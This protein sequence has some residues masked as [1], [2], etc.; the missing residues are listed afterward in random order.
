MTK[1]SPIA[2]YLRVNKAIPKHDKTGCHFISPEGM[3]LG[4]LTKFYVDNYKVIKTEIFGEGFKKMYAQTVAYGQ[5]FI[6][7]RNQSSPIGVSLV[8]IKTYMRK[9]FIDLYEGTSHVKDTEKSLDN[10]LN[11]LAIDENSGVGLYD[12]NKPF[13]YTNIVTNEKFEKLRKPKIKFTEN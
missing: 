2:E 13:M 10:K 4:R 1:I 12:V 7:T 5:R 11:L 3:Y 8:P 9:I 6:Y